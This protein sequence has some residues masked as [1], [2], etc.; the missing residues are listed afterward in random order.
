[1]TVSP[2][3][4]RPAD[5]T[6]TVI[7]RWII[8]HEPG[9]VPEKKRPHP[10]TSEGAEDFL[11]Q[12]ALC[13]PPG[14][15]YTLACLTWDHD[16]WVCSGEEALSMSFLARPR[17]FAKRVQRIAADNAAWLKATPERIRAVARGDLP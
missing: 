15:R 1:M 13:R 6:E 11:I 14:T 9:M 7:K 3:A 10:Q 8:V 5:A 2:G 17:I 16:L 12:L 4:D